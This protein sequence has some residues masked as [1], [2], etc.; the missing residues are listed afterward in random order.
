MPDEPKTYHRR[1]EP[2]GS[3]C[4][5]GVLQAASTSSTG[6]EIPVQILDGG[7]SSTEVEL[8]RTIVSKMGLQ[9]GHDKF[10]WWAVVPG[11]SFPSWLVIRQDD[12]GNEYVVEA[13]LTK[14]QAEEMA[15]DLED[16]GHKQTYWCKDARIA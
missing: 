13:N 12:S 15:R 10:G 1:G 9:W 3:G 11:D 5:L 7:E 6:T 14:E 2:G 8:L 16:R 4:S